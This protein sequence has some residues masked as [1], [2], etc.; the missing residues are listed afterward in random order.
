MEEF[1]KWIIENKEMAILLLITVSISVPISMHFGK[2][3]INRRVT[4]NRNTTNNNYNNNNNEYN[5]SNSYKPPRQGK[6]RSKTGSHNIEVKKILLYSTGIN[7]KVY[8]KKFHKKM[9]HNFGIEIT[10][11]NNTNIQQNVKVGWCIYKN[12][13]EIWKG[14]FN[15]KVNANST[16]SN[17]FYVKQESFKKLK[18]GKYKSQFWVNDIRVQK[19]EFNIYNK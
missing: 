15:K 9:N 2:T 11:K 3:V 5:N 17:D 16:A 14:T 8:T 18:P 12:G 10:L 4:N 13:V 6:S 19:V 7:G 1:L